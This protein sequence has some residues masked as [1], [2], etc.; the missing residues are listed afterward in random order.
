[1]GDGPQKANEDDKK[2]M[3]LPTKPLHT[4]AKTS[5]KEEKQ[6]EQYGPKL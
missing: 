6:H 1:M 5:R 4:K 3:L 2:D